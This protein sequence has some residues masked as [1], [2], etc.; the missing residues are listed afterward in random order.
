[1]WGPHTSG[2]ACEEACACLL[3]HSA[4]MCP[5]V[6]S[7][8]IHL[9]P[10]A[11]LCTWPVL[12]ASSLDSGLGLTQ[13]S[14]DTAT[15]Q[16][17]VLAPHSLVQPHHGCRSAPHGPWA[18]DGHHACSSAPAAAGYC[19]VPVPSTERAHGGHGELGEGLGGERMDVPCVCCAG[20]RAP[21]SAWPGRDVSLPRAVLLRAWGGRGERALR[22]FCFANRKLPR[23]EKA[24]SVSLG[25]AV[26]QHRLMC[27]EAGGRSPK[28]EAA[29]R[30]GEGAG[31]RGGASWQTTAG[32]Q[33]WGPS[34]LPSPHQ[35]HS[36]WAPASVSTCP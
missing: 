31:I 12:S 19:P 14:S 16:G 36:P 5:G 4:L 27:G 22:S 1:M 30:E 17:P 28:A 24:N 11:S 6:L 18:T 26:S 15:S 8:S 21:S 20:D 13:P 2:C 32:P 23:G 7:L 3:V 25:S 33:A 10:P 29:A 35:V 34:W 9:P